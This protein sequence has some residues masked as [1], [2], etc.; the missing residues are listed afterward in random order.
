MGNSMRRR[1]LPWICSNSLD[2]FH[3]LGA[4]LAG[5]IPISSLGVPSNYGYGFLLSLR[6]GMCKTDKFYA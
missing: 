2:S 3:I 4:R 6:P 1:N 5:S